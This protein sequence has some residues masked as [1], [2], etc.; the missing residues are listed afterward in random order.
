MNFKYSFL[1]NDMEDNSLYE[2]LG[3]SETNNMLMRKRLD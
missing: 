1:D 3:Y 2:K